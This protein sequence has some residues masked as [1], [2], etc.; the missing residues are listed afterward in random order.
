MCHMR[1]LKKCRHMIFQK[2]K[3]W[4][5]IATGA[6]KSSGRPGFW[7]EMDIRQ[8]NGDRGN[9]GVQREKSDMRYMRKNSK[10]Y[11]LVISIKA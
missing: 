11:Y 1:S 10:E 8:K 3:Y 7:R 5:C 4:C 9:E 2:G 6:G